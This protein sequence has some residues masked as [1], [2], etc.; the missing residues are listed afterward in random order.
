MLFW[1]EYKSSKKCH[2]ILQENTMKFWNKV[3]LENCSWSEKNSHHVS[4]NNCLNQNIVKNWRKVSCRRY[5]SP[6]YCFQNLFFEKYIHVQ[7]ILSHFLQYNP[8]NYD[9]TTATKHI[10]HIYCLTDIYYTKKLY[11]LRNGFEF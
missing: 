9:K 5:F 11:I 6:S 1:K 8:L 3:L 7:T 10:L 2:H 4:Y